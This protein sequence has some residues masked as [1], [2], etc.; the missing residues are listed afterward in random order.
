[1]PDDDAR[2]LA[3]VEANTTE[4]VTV[5]RIDGEVDLSNAEQV[6]AR[7][8]AEVV[9]DPET[10]ILDLA[11]ARYLDSAGIRLLFDL[12]ERFATHR[13]DFRI[14]V[15]AAGLVH[16]VLELTGVMRQMAVYESVADARPTDAAR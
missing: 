6:R 1:M 15:P 10:V 2:Q 16:K 9:D 13:I 12:G 14:V 4:R 11:G 7:I 8:L 5:V 3:V